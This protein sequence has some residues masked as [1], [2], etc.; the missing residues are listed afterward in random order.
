MVMGV[1][2]EYGMVYGVSVWE[3]ETMTVT[4]YRKR[5]TSGVERY[6][7]ERERATSLPY[8]GWPGLNNL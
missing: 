7:K 5:V 6:I 1:R 8:K 4:S 3:R 2:Y